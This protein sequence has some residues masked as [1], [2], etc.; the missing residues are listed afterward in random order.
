[1]DEIVG[2]FDGSRLRVGLV[3][4]RFNSVITERLEAGA[5]DALLRHGV[6]KERIVLARVPGAFE[7]PTV[8]RQLLASGKVDG[9]VGLGCVIRGETAHYDYIC[10]AAIGGLAA[11]GR[12]TG[13]P[14]MCGVLTT[15]NMAQ[16]MSRAGGK[17]G[18]KGFEAAQ[19]LLE[20]VSLRERIA[21]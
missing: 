6:D 10:D 3:I 21:P 11:I 2:N 20:C 19:G 14:V 8:A 7:I 13:R 18:N 15:E 4:A 12:E 5:I 9:V 1:M 17:M 16:A